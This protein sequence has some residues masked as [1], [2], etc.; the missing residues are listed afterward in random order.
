M[1]S[2]LRGPG[3]LWAIRA[4]LS[5]PENAEASRLGVSMEAHDSQDV[6]APLLT[7]RLI[8]KSSVTTGDP[9]NS[10]NKNMKTTDAL[11]LAVTMA[12]AFGAPVVMGQVVHVTTDHGTITMGVAAQ[13][14]YAPTVASQ[15]KT[16]VLSIS[17]QLKGKKL[18]HAIT[19]S[20]GGILKEQQYSNFGNSA[21]LVLEVTIGAQKLSTNWISYGS[22]DSFAY[23]G[24]TEP[25]RLN[26]LQTL[27]GASTI[28]IEF[29]P[30]LTGEPVTSTF[31]VSGL[32]TEFDKHPE[33]AMK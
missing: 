5:R 17:C 28:S 29:T 2:I 25:E 3:C 22:L 4:N 7:R 6:A 18:S 33:C 11:S 23:Y 10:S 26:F 24:K 13:K 9:N 1:F 8:L 19:F 12:L 30:F 32:R 15:P 16:P 21:S 31:D 14:P 20:P 27:L